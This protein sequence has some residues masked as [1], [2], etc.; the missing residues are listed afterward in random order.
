VQVSDAQAEVETLSMTFS[1]SVMGQEVTGTSQTRLISQ[2][3][4]EVEMAMQF[5]MPGFGTMDMR[6]VDGVVYMSLGE[7]TDGRFVTI[8]LATDPMGQEFAL[9]LEQL[10]PAAQMAAAK[11]AVLEYRQEGEPETIDGVEATP[12]VLVL[13][14][15]AV[16]ELSGAPT[17]DLEGVELPETLEYTMFVGPDDLPRRTV[18]DVMGVQMTMDF[19]G[20]G[21]DVVIEAPSADQVIEGGLQDLFSYAA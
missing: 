9:M 13:D 1:M 21:E 12:Y 19:S 2:D 6:L 3:P 5:E 11:E 7:Q 16:M 8:D 14:T 20:Y 18:T 4:V 10:D 17:E 15:A